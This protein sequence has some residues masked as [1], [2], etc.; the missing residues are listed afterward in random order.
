VTVPLLQRSDGANITAVLSTN[1]T[2][3]MA[4]AAHQLKPKQADLFYF[5]TRIQLTRLQDSLM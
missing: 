5:P 4:S 3:L 2:E 1:V